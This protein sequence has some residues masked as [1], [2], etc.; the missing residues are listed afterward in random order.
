[1]FGAVMRMKEK[2]ENHG[3]SPT[4]LRKHEKKSTGLSFGNVQQRYNSDLPARPDA[5]TYSGDVARS[6]D[7]GR[8]HLVN[9]SSAGKRVAIIQRM[10]N[11]VVQRCYGGQTEGCGGSDGKEQK[12]TAIDGED[13]DGRKYDP[14]KPLSPTNYPPTDPDDSVPPV[15]YEPQTDEE[16]RRMRQGKGPRTKASH[17]IDNIEPHHRGQKSVANGGI[18]DD[19]TEYTHRRGGN[20]ARHS[21]P[22]EL[23]SSQRASEIRDYWKSRGSEYIL[24]GEGI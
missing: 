14:S 2:K 24:Q 10:R 7:I 15:R 22:S 21:L 13:Q 23:T 11:N 5:L 8:E 17:G 20:H 9:K 16:I 6:M 19:L 3:R 12:T 18:I 4:Q 1:M